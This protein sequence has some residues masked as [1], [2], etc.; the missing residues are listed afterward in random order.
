MILSGDGELNRAL[1]A[2]RRLR[3][4]AFGIEDGAELRPFDALPGARP[5]G[6][7][8]Q[9]EIPEAWRAKR[10]G[11]GF[12]DYIETVYNSLNISLEDFPAGS[13]VNLD[14]LHLRWVKQGWFE[15]VPDTS[16]PFGFRRANGV[17]ITPTRML[18]DGGT[19]P[20][21]L[22]AL[23]NFSPWDYGPA[24]LIHDW[25]FDAHHQ[26]IIDNDFD[27]VRDTMMEGLR[28]LMDAG[29]S[30]KSERVF[31]VLYAGITSPVAHDYWQGRGAGE[32]ETQ[33]LPA[34][35]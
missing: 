26:G 19:I 21:F 20:R 14:K 23:K 6:A 15:N 1:A 16:E 34:M 11:G 13:F 31:K 28:T 7:E 29:L 22:W 32:A 10:L 18:T 2:K 4:G 24:F 33:V 12:W 17:L 9:T 27:D 35:S 8:P 3:Q 25:Q 30:E 5:P